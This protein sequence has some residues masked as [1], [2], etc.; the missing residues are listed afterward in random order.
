[1]PFSSIT[2]LGLTVQGEPVDD[3]RVEVEGEPLAVDDLPRA[4][5]R[6]WFLQDRQV[7]VWSGAVPAD[8]AEVVLRMRLQLPNL[9]LPDGAAAQVLQEVRGE[10]PVVRS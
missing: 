8:R 9:T 3:V 4:A 2:G 10:V 7:L 6:Y 1:M 5:D